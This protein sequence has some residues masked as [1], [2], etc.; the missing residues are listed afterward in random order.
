MRPQ[1]GLPVPKG[2]LEM[3]ES[4][5]TRA[6]NDGAKGNGLKVKRGDSGEM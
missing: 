4:G 1:R 3:G 6:G 2:S 5:F